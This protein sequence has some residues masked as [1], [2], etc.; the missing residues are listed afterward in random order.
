MA[1]KTKGTPKDEAEQAATN[2][3]SKLDASTLKTALADLEKGTGGIKE[4]KGHRSLDGSLDIT[5]KGEL[6]DPLPRDSPQT[7]NFNKQPPSGSEIG[8]SDHEIAHLWGPGF[9]D[10]AR[11]GMMYAPTEVN[12]VLQ[13]RTIEDRLRE[14]HK[15][16]RREGATIEVT[17]RATSHPL[18]TWRGHEMLKDVSY[19]FDVRFTDGSTYRIGEVDISVPPPTSSGTSSGR[20]TY[21]VRGGSLGVWSLK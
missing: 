21:K 2:A 14:L 15:L 4:I 6:K 17:A 13:N 18:Q 5:I 11:D 8:L 12:Q 10:E 16:A 1:K 20:F 9:G 7:P 19:R 3:D